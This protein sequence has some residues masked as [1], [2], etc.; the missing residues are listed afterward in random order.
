MATDKHW[1]LLEKER[2]QKSFCIT[3]GKS[4]GGGQRGVP[5]RWLAVL[6][7]R[8]LYNSKKCYYYFL[9]FFF[10]L[11]LD[12]EARINL[13]SLFQTHLEKFYTSHIQERLSFEGERERVRGG[14]WWSLRMNIKTVTSV[15]TNNKIQQ[16]CQHSS[17]EITQ[18]LVNAP[19]IIKNNN[20][21]KKK[22]LG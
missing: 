18:R 22:N 7:Y 9:F 14:D 17:C 13:N 15:Q 19:K 5:I 2:K 1:H 8:L 11:P 10:L 12:G 21:K 16:Q 6:T 20:D 3:I 4:Y